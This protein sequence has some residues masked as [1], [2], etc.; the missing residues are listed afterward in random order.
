MINTVKVNGT[1][2]LAYLIQKLLKCFSYIHIYTLYI[3]VKRSTFVL[4]KCSFV[5]ET[6]GEVI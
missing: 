1:F 5:F 2:N 4:T 3:R 6:T